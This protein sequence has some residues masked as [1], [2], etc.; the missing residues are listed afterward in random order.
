MNIP[1]ANNKLFDCKCWFFHCIILRNSNIYQDCKFKSTELEAALHSFCTF[2]DK[3]KTFPG[4][5]YKCLSKTS[6]MTMSQKAKI[7]IAIVSKHLE[8]HYFCNLLGRHIDSHKL[9][10]L[11]GIYILFNFFLFMLLDIFC[12]LIYDSL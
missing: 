5:F 12:F 8:I 6:N 11:Y 4:P 9:N 2:G 1:N 7:T 3:Y 10:K